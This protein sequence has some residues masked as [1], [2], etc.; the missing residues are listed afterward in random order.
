PTRRRGGSAWGVVGAGS[1]MGA[2][3]ARALAADGRRLV[4]ADQDADAAAATAQGLPGD[5][6]AV[7]CDITDAAAVAGLVERTG[8]LGALVVT[9][10][11]SPSM[12]EGRR[13]YEVNLIATDALVR[14]FEPI[15][16]PGSVGVVLSSM[17]AHQVPPDPAI[18]EIL[19][20]PAAPDL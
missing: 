14:A 6:E 20:D 8:E 15:L 7:A 13:I 3:V 16:R 12:A 4:L 1:G 18:D 5:V 10:G 19:D 17:A 11:L 9:A 2:A